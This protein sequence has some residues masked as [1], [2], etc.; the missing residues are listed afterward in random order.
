MFTRKAVTL[1]AALALVACGES[2]TKIATGSVSGRAI[3]QG[4]T[5]HSGISV[6]VAGF[7]TTTNATGAYSFSE[8]P[9]GTQVVIAVAPDS[10]ERTLT[11]TVT[12]GG[13][14]PDL[15]FTP[16]QALAGIAAAVGG[17]SQGITVTLDGSR[18]TT[19]AADGSYSFSNVAAGSHSLAFASTGYADSISNVLYSPDLGALVA[20]PSR[21][22]ALYRMGVFEMQSG[23]R[24]V[25][26][27]TIDQYA[28]VSP[29]GLVFGYVTPV[30]GTSV[31]PLTIAP[32]AGGAGVVVATNVFTGNWKFGPDS[33]SVAWIADDNGLYGAGYTTGPLALGQVNKLG[34][35]VGQWEF[36]PV[37]TPAPARATVYFVADNVQGAV[38]T[39]SLY[40]KVVA[41]NSQVRIYNTAPTP[42]QQFRVLQKGQRVLF[43]V[44]SSPYTI[45]S[46]PCTA[47][48]AAAINTLD[49]NIGGWVWMDTSAD[50]SK[51]AWFVYSA[52]AGGVGGL[53]VQPLGF[54]APPA[55]AFEAG[56]SFGPVRFSP[57]G[58][59]VVFT[60]ATLA[61]P[62]PVISRKID[63]TGNAIIT[64]TTQP[65]YA[66][67]VFSSN[68]VTMALMVSGGAPGPYQVI[69]AQ[70]DGLGAPIFSSV[71]SGNIN[72]FYSGQCSWYCEYVVGAI[73]PTAGH[74]A[75]RKDGNLWQSPLGTF[76]PVKLPP[77]SAGQPY[78]SPDGQWLLYEAYPNYTDL[79]IRGVAASSS[80][81]V[82]PRYSRASSLVPGRLNDDNTRMAV[83]TNQDPLTGGYDL[84]YVNLTTGAVT[85]IV[86]QLSFY[87]WIKTGTTNRVVSVRRNSPAPFGF[88]DGVYLTTVP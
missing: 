78:Y 18:S 34:D 30:P 27:S 83:L 22:N 41:N 13:T 67:P 35:S 48:S 53:K 76:A 42:V 40:E 19:T 38:N 29:D 50:E 4:R 2:A 70:V 17:S 60:N 5:D 88:Q 52:A 45:Q 62:Y 49:N 16:A 28:K 44:G 69:V 33:A 43:V 14:A 20:D 61:S 86:R 75:Y 26:G 65:G 31:G 58:T 63:G 3:Y 9:T 77:D 55:P 74:V 1:L 15:T 57:D 80:T 85:P 21:N 23:Q 32:V 72:P 12:V 87:D 10:V 73:S 84:K 82:G 59:R 56:T 81:L 46:A 66:T 7:S 64:T 36:S 25:S 8:I 71:D 11:A 24:L 6:T 47:T 39:R 51:V 68:S 79:Y 37:L 54:N